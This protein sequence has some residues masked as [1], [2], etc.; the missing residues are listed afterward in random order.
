MVSFFNPSIRLVC[1]LPGGS[2]ITS[3]TV[4]VVI[5]VI[6]LPNNNPNNK[7]TIK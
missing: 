1:S 6:V 3:A 4:L 5:D 7:Q 2:S